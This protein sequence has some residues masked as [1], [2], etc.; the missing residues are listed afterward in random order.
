MKFNFSYKKK[1]KKKKKKSRNQKSGVID[2]DDCFGALRKSDAMRKR[3]RWHWKILTNKPYVIFSNG[4]ERWTV[5]FRSVNIFKRGSRGFKMVHKR[6]KQM[7]SSWGSKRGVH[8]FSLQIYHHLNLN[9]NLK[10]QNPGSTI[11]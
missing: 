11:K 8:N 3:L 4:V 1:K 10:S 7:G 6:L 5:L 2:R 9:L